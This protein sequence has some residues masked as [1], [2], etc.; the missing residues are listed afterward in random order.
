MTITGHDQAVPSATVI[1]PGGRTPP[2]KV[3]DAG[4]N[5]DIE[6]SH[7]F[8]PSHNGIDF[9]ESLEGMRV[10][11]DN[12]QVVGP[13]NSFG[14][15]SVVPVGSGTRTT[16]GGIVAR[17]GDLNPER[18]VM[19][20]TLAPVPTA[21]VG[22]RYN[23][24]TIG[25]LDYDFGNYEIL[26]TTS[27]QLH[28]GNLQRQVTRKQTPG[29]LAVATFNVENL[30]PKDP[31]SKFDTL[32]H[33]AV[34]NLAAPD[35]LALEEI[36]DNDGPTNDG[37]VAADQT[38]QNLI[39]AIKAAGGPTYE[40]AEIDPTNDADGGQPGGNIRVAF[41]YRTDRGL[42]FIARGNGDATTATTVTAD[43]HH[44]PQLS[45]SPGRIAPTDDA[46]LAS[47]KP[48]VGQFSF[49]GKTVFVI[50][51]HF[52][53][54]LA[55]DPLFGRYQPPREPSAVQRHQQATL[56][57]DFVGDI[58]QID[59]NADVVV[60]GDLNDFDFSQT[61]SII[62]GSHALVDLPST[63]PAAQRYT[64]VY[65][66]NSEVLDHILLSPALARSR[67]DYD[68]QPVHVN[69]EFADQISD[70]D[71]QIVRLRIPTY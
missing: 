69:S 59:H 47:R 35:V 65:Q 33:Y 57:N 32:G 12:A 15:T 25:V 40:S 29:E 39:D 38:L 51:N 27:P 67:W 44:Q 50:A 11:I 28:K 10:E 26:P 55:D 16:R 30:S 22:D 23:G 1:G 66:G 4:D 58:E 52:D 49:H 17:A 3:I 54:K 5:G 46:W 36:Q 68:Y 53:A 34:H 8:D 71:P 31:Q 63:L 7:V 43:S 19:A 14:E 70:H 18:V 61:T 24:A 64:Y 2:P 41:L 42:H 21:S 13:T 6:T 45:L 62:T 20:P 60:V 48:L 9:W 56:V 37:V